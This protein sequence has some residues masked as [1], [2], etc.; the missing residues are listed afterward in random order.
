MLFKHEMV[1]LLMHLIL[2]MQ[3]FSAEQVYRP[4]VSIECA[5][6]LHVHCTSFVK[7]MNVMMQAPSM[8]GLSK[9]PLAC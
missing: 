3:A 2:A 7:S 9:Y 6:Q 5:K 1:W 4:G 8:T